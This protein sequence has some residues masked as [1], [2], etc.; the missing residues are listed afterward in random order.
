[1]AAKADGFSAAEKSAMKERATETR[2]RRGKTT[3]E[4]DAAEVL[5]KIAA[6]ADDDRE[7][8]GRLHEV[9]TAAAP[10]LAPKTWYGMPAYYK[11][12]KVVCFVQDAGKFKYR[13]CTLGFQDAAALDDGAMWPTSY[14]VI[15][16]TAAVA[17]QVTAL[18][19]AAVA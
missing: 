3:P 13:Y 8:V 19:R 7:I 10:E 16:V 6:M 12:G 4:E 15:T 17:K 1:M 14:A 9:I 2:R 11:D 5:A 18:V